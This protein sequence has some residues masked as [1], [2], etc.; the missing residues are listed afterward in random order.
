MERIE[1]T[2]EAGEEREDAEVVRLWPIRVLILSPDR[3][4]RAAAAALIGRR[5]CDVLTAAGEPEAVELAAQER[6]DVLLLERPAREGRR[7][8]EVP[9]RS[10]ASAIDLALARRGAG[11]P[12]VGIVVVSAG[13][14]REEDRGSAPESLELHKWGPFEDLFRAIVRADRHR[15]LPRERR[16]LPWPASVRPPVAD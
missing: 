3:C 13:L 12:P 8:W 6:I 11:V 14:E 2:S 7:S 9:V 16:F 15:R 5:G 10:V 4:F 1:C